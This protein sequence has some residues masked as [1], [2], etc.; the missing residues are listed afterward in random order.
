MVPKPW[1]Y[2]GIDPWT[3]ATVY[4]T[5]AALIL[6]LILS[7]IQTIYLIRRQRMINMLI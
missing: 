7:F 4:L 5:S 6:I 3:N 2:T 1:L